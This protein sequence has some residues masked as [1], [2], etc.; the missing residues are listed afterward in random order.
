[1]TNYSPCPCHQAAKKQQSI[2]LFL[3]KA[4]R[5]NQET[6]AIAA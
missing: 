1:M 2:K 3:L 5:S 4:L 6:E